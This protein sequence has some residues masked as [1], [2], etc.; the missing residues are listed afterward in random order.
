MARLKVGLNNYN[1]NR[2][3][4]KYRRFAA[5][6][7]MQ[8]DRNIKFKIKFVYQNIKTLFSNSMETM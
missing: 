4:F 6:K 7:E 3:Y 1:K 8:N 5:A 2:N